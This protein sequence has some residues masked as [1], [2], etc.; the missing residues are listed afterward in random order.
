MTDIQSAAERVRFTYHD[1]YGYKCSEHGDMSG[2]YVRVPA[3]DGEAIT[4]DWLRSV[5][6]TH[7]SFDAGLWIEN[8]L[9]VDVK[10]GLPDCVVCNA[11]PRLRTRGD[12]RRL[13][14]ALGIPLPAPPEAGE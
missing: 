12:L 7:G 1:G 4:E 6:F 14:L 13:A 8:T 11:R 2:E 5:G 9:G 3:D 10:T